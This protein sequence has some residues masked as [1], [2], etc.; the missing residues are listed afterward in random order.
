MIVDHRIYT[1]RPGTTAAYLE[2][3]EREGFAIQKQ[4]LGDPVGYYATDIGPLNQVIVMWLYESFEDRIKRRKALA[5][6]PGWQEYLGKARAY[7]VSQENRI[8]SPAAFFESWL[9]R[10]KGSR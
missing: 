4:Y 5:A 8:L 9:D 3:Y 1:L 2:L 6:D 10:V 7:F